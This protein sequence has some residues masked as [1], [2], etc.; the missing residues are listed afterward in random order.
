MV[1]YSYLV[2]ILIM[3]F[4]QKILN[5]KTSNMLEGQTAYLCYGSYRYILSGL[6]AFVLMLIANSF[7]QISLPA[8]LISA[9][10]AAALTISLYCSLEAMKNGAIVL[11]S[12]ASSAGLLIPCI[13][14]IFMFDEPMS[15]W[16]FIGI[17]LLLISAYLLIGYSKELNGSFTPKTM[18]L[19]LGGMLSNGSIMVAQKMFSKYLPDT[20]VSVFSFLSFGIAGICMLLLF[21]PKLRSSKEKEKIKNLPLSLFGYGAILSV[22]LLIINQLAT[23]A[24]RVIPSAIMFPINDGGGTIIAALTASIFFK[25]KLTARSISGLL[26]GI[27]AL[28]VINLF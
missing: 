18:L 19:L 2:I 14:G 13:C 1:E 15:P 6:M 17:G 22:A 5:K 26:L 3:K 23:L 12:L 8:V 10:G 28:I 20:N 16:Q 21:L 7:G 4:V 24:G 11:V 25:E 9:L 27:A